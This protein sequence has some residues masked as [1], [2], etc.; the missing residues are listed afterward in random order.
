VSAACVLRQNNWGYGGQP[1]YEVNSDNG[2]LGDVDETSLSNPRTP[3]E[4]RLFYYGVSTQVGSLIGSII[5]FVLVN[6]LVVFQA[7]YPCQS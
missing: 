4:N 5:A 7:S 6:I 2:S 3:A 1:N